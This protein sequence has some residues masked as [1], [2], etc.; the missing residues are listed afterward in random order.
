MLGKTT[1]A[2]PSKTP[3]GGWLRE[4]WS[5]MEWGAGGS[6][7]LPRLEFAHLRVTADI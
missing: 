1:K 6:G 2:Q 3:G 4:G 7:L 5:G